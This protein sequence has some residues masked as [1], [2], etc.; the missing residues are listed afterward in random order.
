[1]AIWCARGPDRRDGRPAARA[2]RPPPANGELAAPQIRKHIRDIRRG[3][4]VA[5]MDFKEPIKFNASRAALLPQE[6][7]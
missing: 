3:Y 7:I 1:M 2:A 5:V 6:P 4:I